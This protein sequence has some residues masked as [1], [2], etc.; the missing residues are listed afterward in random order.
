MAKTKPKESS[1]SERRN[2]P[3]FKFGAKSDVQI[4][5]PSTNKRIECSGFDV[6]EHGIG[7]EIRGDK[8]KL[9]EVELIAGELTIPLKLKWIVSSNETPDKVSR[10]GFSTK[11]PETNLLLVLLSSGY[12]IEVEFHDEDFKDINTRRSA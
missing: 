5:D 7:V 12:D 4:L 1:V 11:N 2:Q 8:F 9:S 3:R 10:Y 6:S